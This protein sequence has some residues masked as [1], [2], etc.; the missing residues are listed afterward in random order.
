M[1]FVYYNPNPLN[2]KI[3]DCVIRAVAKVTN[4]TWEDAY[5]ALAVKGFQLGDMPSANSVWGAYLKSIGFKRQTLPNTCPDC[6]TV[7]DFCEDYSAGIYVVATDGHV[8]AAINGD[9]YDTWD[10]GNE[11]PL[12]YWT[13]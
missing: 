6:Y 10:S 5:I 3:G 11:V 7:S 8:V 2:K 12:Y 9:Y 4:Q 1:G 13:T